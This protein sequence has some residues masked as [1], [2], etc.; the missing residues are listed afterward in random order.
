M[1]SE[2]SN[3]LEIYSF[4]CATEF[5]KLTICLTISLLI[6]LCESIILTGSDLTDWPLLFP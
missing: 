6:P 3:S 1:K 4:A 5:L 2:F